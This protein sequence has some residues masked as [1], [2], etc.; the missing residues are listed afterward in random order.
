MVEIELDDDAG[1]SNI[2]DGDDEELVDNG[3]YIDELELASD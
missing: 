3:E 2:D 1:D